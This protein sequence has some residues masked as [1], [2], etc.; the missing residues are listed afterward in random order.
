MLR[1]ALAFLLALPAAAADFPTLGGAAPIVIGHR[2]AP[3]YLPEHTLA[4]Y[5][6]AIAMGADFIEP[7][8]AMTADGELVAMHDETLERT[9]DA[10]TVF[11]GRP[12]GYAVSGFTAE[13]IARLTVRPT[14]AASAT[15]P[16]FAPRSERALAV[17]TFAEILALLAAHERGTGLRIGV[18]PEAKAPTSEAQLRAIV[19]ALKA[20]GRGG[21]GGR[22]LIQ[23]FDLDALRALGRIQGEAGTSIPL[24]ALGGA[25]RRVDGFV[26]ERRGGAV[27]LAEIALIASGV[28]VS[29]SRG[30]LSAEFVAAAHALG[31]VVHGYTLRPTSQEESDRITAP[32]V[33]MGLD[34][35][36]SDYPDLTHASVDASAAR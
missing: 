15:R 32:L 13:E 33:A 9:T 26:L 10:E 19:A 35:F 4:S 23:S 21:A 3:G 30:A 27:P 28:G 34:G 24:V 18:Y 16:G 25:G 20:A 1:F 11:P 36:F 14:G 22:A 5:E 7:D 2:G 29:V 17:P 8:L 12:G 31:L 6:L